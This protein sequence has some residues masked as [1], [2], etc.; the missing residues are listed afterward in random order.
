MRPAPATAR[1]ARGRQQGFTL[2]EVLLA[3]LVTTLVVAL[4]A[5]AIK[6]DADDSA[7]E[8]TGRYLMQLRGA[9]VDLQLKYEPWLRGEDMANNDGSASA[10]PAPPALTW[11][12]VAGAQVARGGMADLAASGLL[13]VST[14]R[15][16]ALGDA[17]RFL[18][19]R[20][21]TCP[22]DD[23]RTS[24]YVYTCHPI[25]DQRSLR[26][27]ATCQAPA[28]TRAKY[29]Q[30]LLGQVLLA[31]GGYGGHDAMGGTNVRGPLM[32]VPRA[33]FDFGQE[34]GHAVLAAGLDATPFGQ[35]V[36]HGET[37]PVTLHN[38]LTVG[39][40]IQSNTGLLL[41]TA[42]APGAACAVEG[43]YASTANKLLAVCT[44]GVWFTQTG[45]VI[46]G[47]FSDL[48]HDAAVPT[49]RC[50]AGLTPWR[51]VALQATDVT[52]RGS[53][54]NIGGTVG[55]N[56]QGSGHVN[57][58]GSVTVGGAF[59]GTFQNAGS[60][61]VRVA[62]R[63]SIAADRIVIAPADLAARASV[64]QGCKN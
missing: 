10:T 50:P 62:Q 3:L 43:L 1:C 41:N 29:V 27:N 60:S 49:L 46:T 31:A 37:R 4:A 30:A 48:P 45:H 61:Y 47:T 18:L 64:I 33:W 12:A 54:V 17:A 53:D 24:A 2:V 40:R 63:V 13:P 38:T 42:V 59:S 21:G 35:F 32:D 9:V 15:Y 22:G 34:P 23:C 6:R 56:I 16:P 5:G 58:A 11:T 44:G 36:R 39:G 51:Q 52:V 14:P 26:R 20:Q 28:G 25:S 55:G 8:G 57:A 7:A 19:V